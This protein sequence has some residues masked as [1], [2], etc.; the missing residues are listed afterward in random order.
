MHR[1]GAPLFVEIQERTF[2][3]DDAKRMANNL[4]RELVESTCKKCPLLPTKT[5]NEPAHLQFALGE[6]GYLRER[7]RL[8]H[9]LPFEL[10]PRQ[11]AMLTGEQRGRD[12]S[13]ANRYKNKSGT[14]NN[15][16]ANTLNQQMLQSGQGV[17]D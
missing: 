15:N 12:R 13:D 4:P 8:P 6:I 1:G 14:A 5:G 16:P 2:N 17:L 3:A 7:M 10:S 9:P 11:I